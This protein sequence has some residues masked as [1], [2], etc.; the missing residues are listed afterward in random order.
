MLKNY[1]VIAV[2]NLLKHK[3]YTLINILGLSVGMA[4]CI[5]ILL[6]IQYELG[7]DRFHEHA[8]RIY[9]VVL[10]ERAPGRVTHMA[11]VPGPLAPA[12]KEAFPE[13]ESIVRFKPPEAS[14]LLRYE[15][16]GFSELGFYQ[17]DP[18]VFD[19]FSIPMLKGDPKTVL[20]RPFTVVLTE[21]T[22]RKYFGDEDPI[23]KVMRADEWVDLEVTGIMASLP[24][25][26]LR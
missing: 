1:F 3:G 18:S 9:R 20:S 25:N 22:A 21:E 5:L 11:A 17:A 8:N 10:E 6:D 12:M 23:G 24:K 15:D 4:C 16:K 26:T 7:Y 13:V 19:V 14:W 2:R